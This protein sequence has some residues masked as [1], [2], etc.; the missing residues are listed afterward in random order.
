M[1]TFK[2][3]TNIRT[4]WP[5][6]ISSEII[7]KWLNEYLEGT[8]WTLPP[9]C[10]ICSRQIHET[11]VTSI[12]I[13]G[14]NS[15]LPHNLG[16]LTIKNP[17]I[18]QKCLLDCN[19]A[20]FIF[21]CS[22][23]DGLMLYKSAVHLLPGSNVSLD[24]CTLC[25]SSLNKAVM[26]KFAL[27]NDLYQGKLPERFVDLTWVEEMVCA[28][29][30]YTA[31]I[32]RLFQSSDPALPN[33]L[34]GNTCAHEMN[35]VST[36]S[37]LPRTPSDINETLSVV[38]IGPGRFR[39]GLLKDTFRICKRKVW[40]FLVW[41]TAHNLCYLDMLLDKTIIDQY[42]EDGILPGIENNVVEDHSSDMSSIFLVETTGPS[43]HPAEL[44]KDPQSESVEPFVF[45][46]RVGVSNPEGD[47]LSG[48]TF[49]STALRNLVH[50]MGNSTLPDLILHQGSTAIKE[51][52][53]PELM[54]GM[55]PTLWPFGIGGFEDPS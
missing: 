45:L 31:H 20:E 25:Y 36:A 33:V 15:A 47:R 26:P 7:F 55:F 13:N 38:F 28:R 22:S 5:Y 10:A 53:N 23:L 52:K 40:D 54:P 27:A 2:V 44:L 19:S 4:S 37:V 8:L 16:I 34:H 46:E 39:S 9:P 48:R 43:E 35:V 41:L 29:Y 32:T 50:D 17:F 24:V 18:I 21:G 3:A 30:R 49:I 14:G 11:N 42:P 51:Y 6:K 1:T 12:F